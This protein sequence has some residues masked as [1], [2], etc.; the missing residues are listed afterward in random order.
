MIILGIC[1]MSKKTAIKIIKWQNEIAGTKTQITP[2][3]ILVTK[4]GGIVFIVISLVIIFTSLS[5]LI[6]K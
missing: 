6:Q 4:I 5:A 1:L 2:K 3:S